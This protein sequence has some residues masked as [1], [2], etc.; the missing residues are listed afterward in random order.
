MLVPTIT[1]SDIYRSVGK[2]LK[3]HG[4][5]AVIV[6]TLRATELLNQEN[7]NGYRMWKRIICVVDKFISVEPPIDAKPH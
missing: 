4:Q 7:M 6:E 3:Q 1:N 5:N 2:L